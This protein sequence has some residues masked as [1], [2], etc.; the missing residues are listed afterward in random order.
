M[1]SNAGRG[2]VLPLLGIVVLVAVWWLATALLPSTSVLSRFAPVP[3]LQALV[4]LVSS[5]EVLPHIVASLRRIIVG[6]ALAMLL[7]VPIGL[8]V[9]GIR[10]V[11]GLTSTVFQFLRMVSPLAWAPLAIMVFGVGDAPVY[12]LVTMG[13]V[14]PIVLNVAA[15][16]HALDPRWRLL[17]RSLGATREET[18]RTIVWPGIRAH[19][20]TGFRLAV[21]LAWVIVVPAEMLG[22]D[23]G[24]GYA[25]LN[26]RD[27]LAYP[28]L[29]AMIIIIGACGYV[30][31]LG[32]RWVVSEPWR[33][34]GGTRTSI[35]TARAAAVVR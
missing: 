18:F 2:V 25:V 31:D 7:G 26:T 6:L 20:L 35:G 28:E 19:V 33:R 5:G 11:A 23:S 10:N 32:V 1:S 29:M 9:G 15:G 14:W 12:F 30:M 16:V 4:H 24:L 17:S 27:R 3:A 21:G 34:R 22:V 8:A 13:A